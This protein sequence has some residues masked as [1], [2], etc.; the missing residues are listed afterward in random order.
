MQTIEKIKA[1]RK[2]K[3]EQWLKENADALI[4]SNAYVKANNLPLARFRQF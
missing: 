4:S 2:R 1:I 3:Q